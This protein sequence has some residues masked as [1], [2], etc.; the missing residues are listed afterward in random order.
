MFVC[1][2]DKLILGF[3]YSDLTLQKNDSLRELGHQEFL[4][5]SVIY[6]ACYMF[7]TVKENAFGEDKCLN[8]VGERTQKC[9]KEN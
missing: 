6:Q 4:D 2:L 8:S 7:V 1:L 3:R 9:D 5:L